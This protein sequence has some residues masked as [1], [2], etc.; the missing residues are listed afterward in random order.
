LRI[1][2]PIPTS[3][4]KLSDREELTRRLYEEVAG[5]LR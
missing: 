4:M 5:L 3:G 2:Q 1:G